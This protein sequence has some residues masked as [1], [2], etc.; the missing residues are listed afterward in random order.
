MSMAGCVRP[1]SATAPVPLPAELDNRRRKRLVPLVR[2]VGDVTGEEEPLQRRVGRVELRSVQHPVVED[3]GL[4]CLDL[5]HRHWPEGPQW[6]LRNVKSARKRPG[7]ESVVGRIEPT[8]SS[9]LRAVMR[10]HT[11][12]EAANLVKFGPKGHAHEAVR[13]AHT[14]ERGGDRD[15]WRP[16]QPILAARVAKAWVAATIVHGVECL[17]IIR[18]ARHDR[19]LEPPRDFGARGVSRIGGVP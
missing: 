7:L 14:V 9:N 13:R 11:C 2:G 1:S 5:R 4:A 6:P 19:V 18:A 16:L 15:A 10:A 3:V 12:V 8:P 17:G